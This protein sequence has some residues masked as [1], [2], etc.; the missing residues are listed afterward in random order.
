MNLYHTVYDAIHA[1]SGQECTLKLQYIK[2]DKEAVM[3]WVRFYQPSHFSYGSDPFLD[4]TTLRDLHLSVS[5]IAEECGSQCSERC[6]S[7]GEEGRE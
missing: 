4:H 5:S 1:K 6:D 2:T 7:M 3:G